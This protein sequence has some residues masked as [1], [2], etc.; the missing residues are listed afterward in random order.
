MKFIILSLFF[1]IF[2]SFAF[3]QKGVVVQSNE[4]FRD[5][6]KLK[7]GRKI[8]I[9]NYSNYRNRTIG[10]FRFIHEAQNE[11]NGVP[12]EEMCGSYDNTNKLAIIENFKDSFFC[13][14]SGGWICP[15]EVVAECKDERI[16]HYFS[17][18]K[19]R[20]FTIEN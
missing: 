18:I 14:A 1:C 13:T 10:L 7:F 17:P 12:I 5:L 20:L 6:T 19:I 8:E 4:S 2:S 15:F 9:I 3:A 16:M 11:I